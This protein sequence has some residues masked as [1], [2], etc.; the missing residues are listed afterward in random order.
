MMLEGLRQQVVDLAGRLENERTF[1]RH[2]DDK[3]QR[4]IDGLRS[5]VERLDAERAKNRR[6]RRHG[7]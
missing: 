7:C 2:E 6:R 3:L 1:R 5:I 4:Q